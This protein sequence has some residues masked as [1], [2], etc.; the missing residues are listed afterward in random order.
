MEDKQKKYLDK[1]VEFLVKGTKIDYDEGRLYAPFHVTP[2]STYYIFS[3]YRTPF[4]FSKY[5][6]SVYGLTGDEV[7]Y[8]WDEYR[9]I[10]KE[11]V[12]NGK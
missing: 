12:E 3:L 11:K 8:V 10:I 6:K 9:K 1:V 5:C 7:K 2:T 4:L